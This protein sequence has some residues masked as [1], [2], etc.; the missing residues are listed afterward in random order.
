MKHEATQ[1]NPIQAQAV[2][3]NLSTPY[4]VSMA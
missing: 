3:L 2:V 1:S 4:D